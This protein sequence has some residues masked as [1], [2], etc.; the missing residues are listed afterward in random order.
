M[1]MREK[2]RKKEEMKEESKAERQKQKKAATEKQKH[3][4]KISKMSHR[5]AP[6]FPFPLRMMEVI[7]M[8]EHNHLENHVNAS[9]DT[10]DC[11][12][13]LFR[14]IVIIIL[15]FIGKPRIDWAAY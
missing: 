8:V 14:L 5:D 11:I 4:Q 7:D 12:F 3:I 15:F 2:Q 1:E 6:T 9:E 10:N 13:L